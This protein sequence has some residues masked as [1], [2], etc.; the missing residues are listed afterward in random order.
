MALQR[1]VPFTAPPP[2]NIS[3]INFLGKSYKLARLC[4][5]SQYS[6][7]KGIRQ[8]HYKVNRRKLKKNRSEKMSHFRSN[9]FLL[10]DRFSSNSEF[11]P[12]IQFLLYYIYGRMV[13]TE[14]ALQRKAKH[15]LTFRKPLK[16]I[17]PEQL[18]LK[19]VVALYMCGWYNRFKEN[20]KKVKKPFR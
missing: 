11:R 14:M 6:K 17:F 20:R 12:H 8:I 4:T 1:S 2:P 18:F 10:L 19:K 3:K 7:F 13:Y 9:D 16:S 15:Q 5:C